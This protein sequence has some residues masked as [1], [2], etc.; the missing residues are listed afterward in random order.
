MLQPHIRIIHYPT[1]AIITDLQGIT[2]AVRDILDNN[3]Q[4]YSYNKHCARLTLKYLNI[5]G[6][7]FNNVKL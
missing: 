7:M 1:N 6:K 3:S 2:N 5:E 4:D